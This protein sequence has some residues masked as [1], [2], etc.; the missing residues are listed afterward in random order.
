MEDFVTFVEITDVNY[1]GGYRFALGACFHRGS[2]EITG[3][4][5]L[6]MEGH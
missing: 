2:Y 4:T 5:G 3:V 1:P 6:N